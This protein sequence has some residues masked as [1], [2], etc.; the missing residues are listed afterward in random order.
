[1]NWKNKMYKKNLGIMQRD[2]LTIAEF[3]VQSCK[4]I[5]KGNFLDTTHI[6]KEKIRTIEYLFNSRKHNR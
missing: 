2:L 6:L 3:A 5:H 1:M 4:V